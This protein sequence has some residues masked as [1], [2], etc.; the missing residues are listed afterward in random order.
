MERLA[1]QYDLDFE[2]YDED[3]GF[4]KDEEFDDFYDAEP[5]TDPKKLH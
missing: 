2:E 4:S 1:E 5:P 3:L